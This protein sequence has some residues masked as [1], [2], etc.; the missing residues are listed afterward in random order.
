[1]CPKTIHV[2]QRLENPLAG[3]EEGHSKGRNNLEGVS[4]YEG[5]PSQLVSLVP[6]AE[7][8]RKAGQTAAI[9]RLRPSKDGHWIECKYTNTDVV[10]FRR[11][12]DRYVHCEVVGDSGRVMNGH[13]S[14]VDVLCK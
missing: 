8:G 1:M 14:I 11:L 10:I 7:E 4:V 5:H 13:P 12:E 3:W 2:V 6:D 9:W